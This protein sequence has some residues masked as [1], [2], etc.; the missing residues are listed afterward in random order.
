MSNS[1]DVVYVL[2]SPPYP[3]F[4]TAKDPLVISDPFPNVYTQSKG[5]QFLSC[6][7]QSCERYIQ[8]HGSRLNYLEFHYKWSRSRLCLVNLWLVIVLNNV[9]RWFP[10]VIN[11]VSSGEKPKLYEG[12]LSKTSHTCRTTMIKCSHIF[13][14]KWW[15]HLVNMNIKP[16]L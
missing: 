14:V 6:A 12:S 3:T 9:D 4:A 1:W 11:V 8:M 5:V 7:W 15:L 16:K 10:I 13:F 2:S